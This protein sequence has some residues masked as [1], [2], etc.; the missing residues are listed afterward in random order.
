MVTTQNA[1]NMYVE[2]GNLGSEYVFPATSGSIALTSQVPMVLLGSLILG[3]A[4]TEQSFNV[5]VTY[6]WYIIRLD[7]TK[8]AS[9]GTGKLGMRINS[10]TSGYKQNTINYS[11]A[12]NPNDNA[13]EFNNGGTGTDQIGGTI[14]LQKMHNNNDIMA[15]GPVYASDQFVW[16]G[17]R[18]TTS[19][20]V[21]TIK[22]DDYDSDSTFSGSIFFYGMRII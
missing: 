5:D 13:F 15:T 8:H 3:S 20:S 17:G 6:G 10:T 2:P 4:S 12:A 18:V 11:T 22:F 7:I 14:T 21:A 16:L 1:I 19:G 9:S